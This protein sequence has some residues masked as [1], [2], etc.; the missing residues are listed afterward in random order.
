MRVYEE[1]RAGRTYTG[2]G[3]VTARERLDVDAVDVADS[4][5]AGTDS[6]RLVRELTNHS[7]TRHA[8]VRRE[9]HTAEVHLPQNPAGNISH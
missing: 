3:A 5:V 9:R 8:H 7:W 4:D 2:L 1:T 6:V